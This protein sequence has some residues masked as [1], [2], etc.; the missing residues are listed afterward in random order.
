MKSNSNKNKYLAMEFARQNP[1]IPC[2]FYAKAGVLGDEPRI[3]Q[4]GSCGYL[5]TFRGLHGFNKKT[6]NIVTKSF[7]ENVLTGSKDTV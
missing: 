1:E 7:Y 3:I 6:T 4:E 5:E 2:I